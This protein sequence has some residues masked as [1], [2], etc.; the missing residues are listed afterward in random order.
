MYS[1]NVN[2]LARLD[3]LR[4]YAALLVL[5]FHSIPHDV[6][7]PLAMGVDLFFTLSGFIFMYIVA[8]NE[9][10]C[11]NY[12]KFLYNRCCRILPLVLWMFFMVICT[13]R[14]TFH[15]TDVFQLLF[16][17]MPAGTSKFDWGGNN[18]SVPW[19]TVSVEFCFYFIFPFLAKF[20]HKYGI[21][22]LALVIAVTI[23]SK[24]VIFYTRAPEVGY[25]KVFM[26]IHYSIIGHLDTFVVGMIAGLF[27]LKRQ[28]T[29]IASLLASP[30]RL[31]ISAIAIYM[32]AV[33]DNIPI[34]W[35][36]IS[37]GF[38]CS[39]FILS[40][41][42]MRVTIPKLLDNCLSKLGTISFSIY[43]GHELILNLLDTLKVKGSIFLLLPNLSTI[44]QDILFSLLIYLP[45]VCAFAAVTYFTI[46]KPF[47][48]I[49]VK[50][51]Q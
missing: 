38:L 39:V 40:Y 21:K 43:L 28:N 19:W 10:R 36:G 9:E 49:R 20:Y 18:L 26:Q 32:I 23:L 44:Y 3:H 42:L 30:L 46:E 24:I 17:N 51:L 16:L 41:L 2:Y 13:M 14:E 5:V 34:E 4:F 7:K 45:F 12:G 35:Y 50:Y 47:L 29:F 22:Y 8:S 31:V 11:L 48:E 15:A 27:Y 25:G 6:T 37:Y 33:M 1:Q